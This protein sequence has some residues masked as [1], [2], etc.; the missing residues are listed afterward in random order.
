MTPHQHF[1]ALTDKLVECLHPVGVTAK[2]RRLL[3]LLQQRI[4]NIL[5]PPPPVKEQ[6]VRDDTCEVEHWVINDTPIITIPRLMDPPAIM[7]SQNPTA[8]QALKNTPRLHRRV[9]R[10]NTPGIILIKPISQVPVV[11]A[12]PCQTTRTIPSMARQELVTQLAIDALTIAEDNNLRDIFSPRSLLNINPMRDHLRFKQFACPMVHPTTG[13]TISSYT[14]LMHDPVTAETWQM[15]FGKDFSGMAQGDNKTG[16]KGTNAMFVMTHDKIYKVLAQKKKFTYG[17]PV[18]DYC[19]QNN[20]PHRIRITAGGNLVKYES[21]P[22]VQ[23]ADLD[24]AKLHWNS[25]I[26]TKNAKYVCLDIKNF[27]LTARLD[28]FEYM[29]MPLSLFP[30]WIQEQYN[31]VALALD[32]YVHL[33][34]I[35]AVW[36]LLQAGI[37]ANKRLRCKLAPFGYYEHTNTPGLWY[38]KTRPIS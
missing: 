33:E 15:A 19:P 1:C 23:T 6:W 29:R 28:Y 10:N 8:K 31:M 20:D 24:M 38:H 5:H 3:K 25:V 17:N 27:Y 22:L 13:K 4:N 11:S 21:S 14:Q 7:E 36:G 2:G 18:V 16:Q 9:T 32:G 35:W 30:L 12:A 34:M 37:M 26:S